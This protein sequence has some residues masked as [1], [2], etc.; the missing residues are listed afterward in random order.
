MNLQHRPSDSTNTL[1]M[2][3]ISTWDCSLAALVGLMVVGRFIVH[4][5]FDLLFSDISRVDVNC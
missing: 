1:Q 3:C 2:M 5:H 4:V